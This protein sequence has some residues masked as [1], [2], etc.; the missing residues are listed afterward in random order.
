MQ[1]KR[2]VQTGTILRRLTNP[3][4]CSLQKKKKTESLIQL[5]S[6]D[7]NYQIQGFIYALGLI[8]WSACIRF[9][10]LLSTTRTLGMFL[11]GLVLVSRDGRPPS[12]GQILLRQLF[13]PWVAAVPGLNMVFFVLAWIRSDGRFVHDLISCTGC[14][15]RWDVRMA[16]LRMEQKERARIRAAAKNGKSVDQDA[17]S[18]DE[19][20]GRAVQFDLKE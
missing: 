19:E 5:L 1:S 20:D 10:S 13:Q 4:P 7:E 15:Y 9:I 2:S 17:A 11:L 3:L 16:R 12:M 18:G 14:A 6:N 8:V